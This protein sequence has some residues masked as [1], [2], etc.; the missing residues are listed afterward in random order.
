MA[1]YCGDLYNSKD[2]YQSY[3]SRENDQEKTPEK[4]PEKDELLMDSEKVFDKQTSS[5]DTCHM[6]NGVSHVTS[7]H[8]SHDEYHK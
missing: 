6:T 8:D 3:D 2:T 1:D 4:N 7:N 5:H